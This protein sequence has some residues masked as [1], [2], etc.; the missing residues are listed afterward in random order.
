MAVR[1]YSLDSLIKS[2]YILSKALMEKIGEYR[3]EAIKKGFQS[4]MFGGKSEVEIVLSHN[5][6]FDPEY[7]PVRQ[8]YN[9]SYHFQKH[10]YPI[11]GDLK[12]SGEE[13]DCAIAIER[14]PETKY[15]VRN[16]AREPYASFWLPT[17]EDRF[18]PDFVV[19]L[20]DERILVIEYKGEHLQDT[21]DTKE[22]KNI[23]EFWEVASNGSC[24]FL[25]A[26]KRDEEGR[27]V[28]KQLLD[29]VK[30]ATRS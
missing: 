25:L 15:W 18:Y 19:K 16:L 5:F 28:H 10:Y 22:K 9:G 3:K 17:S 4:V 30:G 24:L 27:D 11:I 23:G 14:L 20:E 2:K 21:K 13:Y 29:K 12:D 6:S 8:I 7:Y 26:V 1:S